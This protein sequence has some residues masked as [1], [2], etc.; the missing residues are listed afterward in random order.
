MLTTVEST[1]I[2]VGTTFTNVGLDPANV[3]MWTH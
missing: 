1:F 2:N 3:V